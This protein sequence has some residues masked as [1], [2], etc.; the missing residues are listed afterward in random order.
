MQQDGRGET[1]H[2]YALRTALIRAHSGYLDDSSKLGDVR[3]AKLDAKVDDP[4]ADAAEMHAK[5]NQPM[6]NAD[7]C[8]PPVKPDVYV[9][10][11]S[12]MNICQA[13][14]GRLTNG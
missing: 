11:E 10:L 12:R 13:F 9:W 6:A 5:V 3:L 8:R 7:T 1:G 14:K 4:I 2:T